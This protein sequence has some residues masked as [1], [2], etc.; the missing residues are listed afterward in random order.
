MGKTTFSSD[1]KRDTVAQTPNAPGIDADVGD[2]RD[3]LATVLTPC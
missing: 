3:G 2:F 1:V